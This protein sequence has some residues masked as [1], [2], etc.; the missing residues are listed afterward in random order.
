MDEVPAVLW[1]RVGSIFYDSLLLAAVLFAATALL[2]PFNAGLAISPGNRVFP[3]YLLGVSFLYFGWFWTHGG[4]TVGMKVWRVRALAD[5][6]RG[7]SWRQSSIRFGVAIISW[8][9]L[10]LGF[11]WMV[12]SPTRCTWHDQLSRTRLVLVTKA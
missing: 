12:W 1:R 4:Q 8:L 11:L 2:L 6:D 3:I 5:Q 9:P 10:G 7:L